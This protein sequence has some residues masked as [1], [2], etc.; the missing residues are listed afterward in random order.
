MLSARKAR[1]TVKVLV[2][3]AL[4]PLL[5]NHSL[6]YLR[7]RSFVT[8]SRDG[9]LTKGCCPVLQSRINVDWFTFDPQMFAPLFPRLYDG[10]LHDVFIQ[11]A[12]VAWDNAPSSRIMVSLLLPGPMEADQWLHKVR[13]NRA[14]KTAGASYLEVDPTQLA[15]DQGTSLDQARYWAP[16]HSATQA[17]FSPRKFIQGAK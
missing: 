1:C 8:R 11:K 5:T 3:W 4:L 12:A 9:R 16:I 10:I 17:P 13:A 7:F 6:C 14:Q 15:H 2:S